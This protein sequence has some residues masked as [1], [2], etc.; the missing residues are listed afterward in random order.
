MVLGNESRAFTLSYIPTPFYFYVEGGLSR[1]DSSLQSSCLGLLECWI[2]A[3]CHHTQLLL[4]SQTSKARLLEVERPTC[5]MRLIRDVAK[6]PGG[7][8][9]P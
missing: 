9:N 2:T 3:M 4:T 6:G 8:S 5:V 1:V 7:H